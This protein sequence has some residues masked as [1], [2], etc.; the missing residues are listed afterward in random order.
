MKINSGKALKADFML[1]VVAVC[2]GFSYYGMKIALEEVTTFTLNTY[3]FLGAFAVAVILSFPKL[4]GVNR[5]MLMYSG[6]IGVV[7]AAVYAGATIGVQYTTLSNCA[8]LCATTVFFVPVLEFILY[9][10][11]TSK[12]IFFAITICFIGI[13]LM[14]LKE[15]FSFNLKHLKGDLISL[16]TGVTYAL[17]IVITSKAVS[18]KRVDPYITGVFS[19]ASC[20]IVMLILSITMENMTVPHSANV[21][22][23]V[24]FLAV[25]CTGVAFIIQPIAQQ[26]TE[27][28]HVGI[29]F[30]L[31]P[32]FA[33][34]IAFLFA[35]EVLTQK[36][37]FGEVLILI[38]LFFMEVDFGKMKKSRKPKP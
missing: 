10:K 22:I 14:T 6:A 34:I 36:Q 30:S 1:L 37:V 26:H 21:W 3:R 5:T 11:K 7:L 31:E 35:G 2:W 9:R 29:I 15:D 28:S 8:F 19:L 24:V 16:S 25:F 18:D 27:P 23:A 32:V 13:M 20:G 33:G 38:A 12:K 4:R 17:E